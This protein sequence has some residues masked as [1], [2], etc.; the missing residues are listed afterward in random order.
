MGGFLLKCA[1]GFI[2]RTTEAMLRWFKVCV[3]KGCSSCYSFYQYFLLSH[4]A[5][6][7]WSS[8]VLL[9]FCLRQICFFPSNI[10]EYEFEMIGVL[11]AN[12]TKGRAH[13]YYC[14]WRLPTDVLFVVFMEQ[15]V[16][17]AFHSV[18]SCAIWVTFQIK[19]EVENRDYKSWLSVCFF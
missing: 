10:C 14:I 18:S 16:V 2:Y 11:D 6:Q 8:R 1:Y 7:P 12:T 13:K 17:Q 15:D 3:G 9:G 5:S 19:V 4:W